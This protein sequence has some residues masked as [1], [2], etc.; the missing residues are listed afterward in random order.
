VKT[1]TLR[2]VAKDILAK[3]KATLDYAIT[4]QLVDASMA[5]K[6]REEILVSLEL[7][8]RFRREYESSLMQHV[9]KWVGM[10][11][12]LEIAEALGTKVAAAVL[13][14]DRSKMTLVRRWAKPKSVGRRRLAVLA[15]SGLVTDGQREAQAVLDLCE[16]L[17][18]EDH[19]VLVGGVASL[20]RDTTKVDAKAVQDFLFRRSI[21]GNPDIL[22]AGSENDAA[23]RGASS[24]PRGSGR[25]QHPA[26]VESSPARDTLSPRT[27]RP[28]S[29]SLSE[30]RRVALC[31]QGFDRARPSRA[32]G[33]ADVRKVVAKLG[34][35]QFDSVNVVA[36]AHHQ[37]LFSRLGAFDTALLD[38]L[39]AR[40]EI[41][42]Q[43][44]HEACFV[45]ITTGLLAHRREEWR[46]AAP[47]LPSSK[48]TRPDEV[49]EAVESR[50]AL[51]ADELHVPEGAER[52]LE[53]SWVGT[54]SRAALETHFG[55]GN[56]AIVERRKGLVRAY[57][58]P[59]RVVPVHLR[60]L[61]V[62]RHEA[63]RMLLDQAGR[64]HGVG[65]A[66]DLAD[67]FRMSR[68]AARPRIADLV[69]AKR[70][71][72]VEVEGFREKAYLHAEA[73]VPRR[74]DARAL[75]SPFDPVVWFRPRTRRLFA[76]GPPL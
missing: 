48:N 3:H 10:A 45:P 57:D 51:T 60:E 7:L 20:L 31:A 56:L 75:L 76:F 35:L 44:A 29:L 49:L 54:A 68:E 2:T 17:L 53:S 21:D 38:A 28:L 36:R 25:A 5:R 52:R 39:V 55:R 72:E 67:Y 1:A 22:R 15:A 37:V 65:T 26:A 69:S 50:G 34:H 64:A 6:V 71:L 18:R 27:C 24:Q 19:P 8:E 73:R 41:T 63:E 42:E 4:V 58:L 13:A 70:L 40:G 62:P 43:W 9:D 30:A 32:V 74:I 12:D 59:S 16:L 11:D 47:L 14:L 23:R 61:S 46:A 33:L 66:A